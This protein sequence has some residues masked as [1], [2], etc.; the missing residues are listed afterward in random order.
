MKILLWFELFGCFLCVA[1]YSACSHMLE[2][3]I[4]YLLIALFCLPQYFLLPSPVNNLTYL[5]HGRG[6]WR[7]RRRRTRRRWARRRT[8]ARTRPL[9]LLPRPPP[10]H[11]WPAR[12]TRKRKWSCFFDILCSVAFTDSFQKKGG[13]RTSNI[14]YAVLLLR[15][16]KPRPVCNLCVSTRIFHFSH[17]GKN[18]QG[19][20]LSHLKA[21]HS[22]K[23]LVPSLLFPRKDQLSK[24]FLPGR[25]ELGTTFTRS[26]ASKSP[27]PSERLTKAPTWQ[28]QTRLRKMCKKDWEKCAKKIEKNV[29]RRLRK[30]CKEIWEKCTN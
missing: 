25:S 30:M 1:R 3:D 7:R 11:L 17:F 18:L 19:T 20:A 9:D 21:I 5:Q 15:A 12:R 24:L 2:F 16:G 4:Q 26:S 23:F 22:W 6:A 10:A 28:V 29:Q 14:Y 8:S 13:V 27:M